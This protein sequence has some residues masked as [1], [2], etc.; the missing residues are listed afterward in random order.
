MLLLSAAL[1]APL[2]ID[3]TDYRAN[4][5]AQASKILGQPV[6]VA[7]AASARLLPFPSVTFEDV[8]VGKDLAS[9]SLTMARFSMDAELAP[10]LSGEVLIFDMRVSRPRGQVTVHEDGTIN[11]AL[12]PASPFD[13]GQVKIENLVVDGGQ[14]DFVDEAQGTQHR[15]AIVEATISARGLTGPWRVNAKLAADGEPLVVEASTGALSED[16][17]LPLRMTVFPTQ[18]S[19]AIEANG[20]ATSQAGR[21]AYAGTFGLRPAALTDPASPALRD[22]DGNA[23]EAAEAFRVSG[24]FDMRPEG[25]ELPELRLETGDLQNPYVAN[26]KGAVSFGAAPRF[27]LTLDGT[28]VTFSDKGDKVAAGTSLEKRITAFRQFVEAVPVPSMPGVIAVKLPAVVAGDTTIREVEFKAEPAGDAWAVKGMRATLPGRTKLEADGLLSGGD[29]FGFKGKLIVASSQPSGLATWLAGEVGPAIRRLEAAGFSADVDLTPE[30]QTFNQLELAI[31]DSVLN[32]SAVRRT[33]GARPVVDLMLRGG[34]LN[35]DAMPDILAGLVTGKGGNQLAGHDVTLSLDA[36]PVSAGELE[37][38]GLGI[39][40]RLKQDRADIDRLMVTD[41]AGGSI[42][43]TGALTGFPD[44]VSGSFDAALVSA[45][46]SEFIDMLAGAFPDS[47]LLETAAARVAATPG[48]LSDMQVSAVASS[49]PSGETRAWTL[50]GNGTAASGKASFSGNGSASADGLASPEGQW[51]A[52]ITQD[53][54]LNFL[55]LAGISLVPLG[56]PGPATLDIVASGKP[57]ADLNVDLAFTGEGTSATLSGKYLKTDGALERFDGKLNLNSVDL[58]PYLIATGLAF[59]GTGFGTPVKLDTDVSKL[60]PVV[61]LA[62]VD[63][64]TGDL[65]TSGRLTIDL[66]GERTK[67][68]G[69]L[70][71]GRLDSLWLFENIAGS[72]GMTIGADGKSTAPFITDPV[73]PF[74]G[75][76]QLKAQFLGLGA[77]GEGTDASAGMVLNGSSLRLEQISSTLAGGTLTGAVSAANDGGTVSVSAD[78]SLKGAAPD[79]LISDSGLSGKASISGTVSVT[80]KSIEA[81]R[82]SLTGSGVVSFNGAAINGLNPDGFAAMLAIPAEQGKAPEDAAVRAMIGTAVFSGSMPFADTSAAWTAAGGKVRMPALRAVSGKSVLDAVIEADIPASSV[83]VNGRIAFDAGPEALAGAETVVPFT[84]SRTL[85]G[86]ETGATEFASDAQP[87]T[88]YLTQRALEAEQARVEAMQAALT[89]KQR[90]R[91]DLRTVQL[92]Y[93]DRDR[94]ASALEG[95]LRAAAKIKGEQAQQLWLDEKA[96]LEEEARLQR[97]AEEKARIEAEAKAAE[98]A[99]KAEAAAKAAEAA[100][101]AA[102]AAK[103]AQTQTLPDPNLADPFGAPQETPGTGTVVPAIPK[104]QLDLNP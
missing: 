70:S 83:S 91:R 5:E 71:V 72:G 62:G 4:F 35:L 45:D 50:S 36:G 15:L 95:A 30:L 57:G 104:L 16:G 84:V 14:I 96:R 52:T 34:A 63:A 11:W 82:A 79:G 3:W 26:G 7:G 94:R 1:I 90:L 65:K 85:G 81:L 17:T 43:A 31:G 22:G 21:I 32:G 87:M 73:L 27:D 23:N 75:R 25:L 40:V 100:A 41:L 66:S 37:A 39:S 49:A 28:Q 74:D 98:E 76:I 59:P 42:S 44:Q 48:L 20:S 24:A 89:D 10:F 69:D 47:A 102:E 46:G 99:V 61:Q 101:K 18:R 92:A 86:I 64:E 97:E 8:R 68:N 51:Q 2:F 67:L 77:L 93:A 9:P 13:P 38:K 19:V 56:A 33:D 78:M 103:A 60:G 55:T 54:P 6:T 53:E 12:R 58:D 29:N 80:G 88:Q